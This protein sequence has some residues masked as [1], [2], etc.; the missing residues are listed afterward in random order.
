MCNMI[1]IFSQKRDVNSFCQVTA[2]A[3]KHNWFS[4]GKSSHS[5]L[6]KFLQFWSGVAEV[7]I[8]LECGAAFLGAYQYGVLHSVMCIFVYVCVCVCILYIY[9]NM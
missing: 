3:V 7:Y 8:L 4:D 9:I 6:C 1:C 5:I 2:C